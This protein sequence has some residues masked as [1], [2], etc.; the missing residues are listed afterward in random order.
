M[1]STRRVNRGEA[2]GAWHTWAMV[3]SVELPEEWFDPGELI[4]HPSE[5]VVTGV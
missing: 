1:A 5:S 3:V 2:A 4:P